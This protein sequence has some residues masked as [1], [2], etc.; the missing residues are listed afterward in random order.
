MPG[1]SFAHA[2]H[3][4]YGSDPRMLR[5][6]QEAYLLAQC[7]G[8]A[9]YDENAFSWVHVPAFHLPRG[10]NM[11]QTDILL[12]LPSKYPLLPPDGFY[13]AQNLRDSRGRTPGHYFQEGGSLNR[14]ADRG[15]AW[16][17]IHANR[18]W[19]PTNDIISGHNL[20]KYLELIRAILTDK[21]R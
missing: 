14:Y 16:F 3:F 4:T 2:P 7:Y 18:A 13:L 10:W 9:N 8:A 20:I 1:P 12:E 15:W 17:C 11:S 5:I 21:G 19:N 6:V